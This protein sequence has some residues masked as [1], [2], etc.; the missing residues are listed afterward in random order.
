LEGIWQ[1][2]IC[3]KPELLIMASQSARDAAL[4]YES[5][6]GAA[7]LALVG[8]VA[9]TGVSPWFYLVS[10]ASA[11]FLVIHALY[12]RSAAGPALEIPPSRVGSGQFSNGTRG[13]RWAEGTFLPRIGPA[14]P[15]RVVTDPLGERRRLPP[16]G[17]IWAVVDSGDDV[18]FTG[19]KRDCEDW[20][21]WQDNNRVI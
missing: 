14:G 16:T 7:G 12:G 1:R 10:A 11:A 15:W 20:L 8:L 3:S 4:T 5:E 19:T 13:E 21:D 17:D 18:V 2:P 9:G 6:V